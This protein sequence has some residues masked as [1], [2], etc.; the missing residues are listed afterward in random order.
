MSDDYPRRRREDRYVGHVAVAIPAY[1][2]ADGIGEFLAEID[3]ALSPVVEKLTLVVVD[4]AST[5]GT[6]DV[7]DAL[8]PSLSAGVVMVRR[9]HNRGHGPNLREAYDRSLAS[10]ADI[11]LQ[12][13]GD[14]QFLGTDLRRMLVLLEDGA[15]SVC[16]VRRFRQDPW[17]RMTLTKFV[18][19]YVSAAFGVPTRDANCPLRGYH[20]SVLA[21]LLPMLPDDAMVPNL[22]LTILAAREGVT[23]VE[24]D[25]T[26]QVR[27]G[28][29]PHGTTW[30]TRKPRSIVPWR[31]VKFSA[32]ALRESAE[33][34][35][36]VQ[37]ADL[38]DGGSK[39][40]F[41]RR[42]GRSTP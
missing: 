38:R 22:Y 41:M 19:L 1:N 16:G 13:D 36:I 29:S 8:A 17:V 31:L 15:P 25:V 27:R 5:D 37:A 30:G 35:R 40:S 39:R 21:K 26:H 23:M 32:K 18:R 20:A 4:D 28:I 6:A 10:E 33:F 11:V 2:E 9:D 42:N 14:G 34:R 3:G 24:V 12:V 7:V